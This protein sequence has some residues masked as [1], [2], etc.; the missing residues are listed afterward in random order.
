MFNVYV[1]A[2]LSS[3]KVEYQTLID[4][5]QACFVKAGADKAVAAS[6][7]EHLVEAD[8]MGF[9]THGVRRLPYNVKQ[10]TAGRSGADISVLKERAAVATWDANHISGLYVV[11]KAIDK[12]IEMARDCGTGTIVIRRCEHAASMAAYL[13]RATRQG[14]VISLMASTPAQESV[15]PFG[16]KSRVFSPNPFG[17]GVPA[18]KEDLLLDISFSVTAAGKVRQAYDRNELLPW[19]AIIGS[20]GKATNDPAAY[21]DDGGAILPLGG[22]D[23]G[24]KG[25]GLCLMSEIW[26]MSLSNYGRLQG[27]GDGECNSVFVQIMDPDAF[28]SLDEFKK[29]TDDFLKRCRDAEAADSGQKVRIPGERAQAL[30]K[31]QLKHGVVLDELTW[32]RLVSCAERLGLELPEH[33]PQ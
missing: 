18:T 4:W 5:A 7:A 22:T 29:V 15:A 1:R 19:P 16:G 12:A 13:S 3:V 24:Y 26:T 32:P 33:Q 8:L 27:S 11:P 23:L 14:M 2:I 25:Y 21:I 30:K 9:S 28:G 17:I 31:E 10:L 6:M 20:D